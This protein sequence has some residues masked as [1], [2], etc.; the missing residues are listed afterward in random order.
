MYYDKK[1]IGERIRKTRI[2]YG[3]KSR[4]DLG[5]A[6]KPG[7]KSK[8]RK[9]IAKWENGASL[10]SLED[11]TMMCQLFDCEVGF[12]LCE[13]DTHYREDESICKQ[14]GLTE[15]AIE[16]LRRCNNYHRSKRSDPTYLYDGPN[17]TFIP[18]FISFLLSERDASGELLIGLNALDDILD[19]LKVL[20]ECSKTISLL[21][22]T[23][24]S[25]CLCACENASEMNPLLDF[26]QPYYEQ[27]ID[28]DVSA[29]REELEK[30]ARACGGTVEEWIRIGKSMFWEFQ[31]EANRE[32]TEYKLTK[33]MISIFNR[34]LEEDWLKQ[35]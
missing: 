15:E 27:F 19:N 5:F 24:R 11:L 32:A 9:V 18:K 30:E 6:L 17:K 1:Q 28:N 4:E 31:L 33:A 12:L 14:T 26:A 2:E 3:Y 20:Y 13:Y 8:D 23:I 22:P 7:D 10:P 34:F 29:Y 25:I 35:K 21:P 16:C